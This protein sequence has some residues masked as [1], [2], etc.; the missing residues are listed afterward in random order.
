MKHEKDNLT[1]E[2][3][4]LKNSINHLRNQLTQTSDK[5]AELIEEN[6]QLRRQVKYFKGKANK[7]FRTSINS[8]SK[9]PAVEPRAD[10]LELSSPGKVK[11][12]NQSEEERYQ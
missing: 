3:N 10:L 4:A 9:T 7:D 11:Y 2:I 12:L 1:V 5:E 8:P 6:E